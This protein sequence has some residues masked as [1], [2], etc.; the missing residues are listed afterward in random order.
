MPQRSVRGAR[1]SPSKRSSQIAP[2]ADAVE[3]SNELI[4]EVLA[5]VSSKRAAVRFGSSRALRIL[6]ERVPELLYPHFDF[7][8]A[9]LD[10]DNHILQWNATFTLANLARVDR[11]SRIDAILD[12]YLD[13]ISGANM[14]SAA[15]AIHGAATIGLAKPYL[16]KLSVP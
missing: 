4:E 6:S 7:F 16:V 2:L 1:A 10:H 11:E 9:M 13:L 5:G 8:V 12:R 14:I 3:R 15:N